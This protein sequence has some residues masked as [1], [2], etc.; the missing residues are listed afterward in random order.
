M[1]ANGVWSL[2]PLADMSAAEFRDWQVLLENRTGVVLN[3][4]RRTFLQASL[5][6]RMRELGIG[7]YHSYYRQVTDGPRGAVEWATLLDRL[8][9][10]E[11]RFFR[12]P[13]LSSCSSATW[14]SACAAKACRGPG[15]CGASAAP[16]A[17]NP[18]RWRCAPRRCCAGRNGKIFRRHRNGYQPSRPA[19]GAAGELS[20]PQ[21]GATGGRAGRTLLRTPGRRQLQRENDTDRARL[22]RPAECAGPGEGALVRH[23]RDFC[24][25]LLIYFR[26][27]RRREILNRLAERLAPGGLLVIGVGEVV[28]WS[29]PELEPVADERVLAFT[30]KGYSGT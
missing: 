3:E 15:P 12:H 20:G 22:L 13:R 21:A 17:R 23:G 2:Q 26:R 9:V 25:N 24:Q 28:D 6:A 7:D 18:T 27:W 16:A 29:H 14:A 5:T 11:T 10:Q 30:R 19:A 4:Q 8:T 1:Q